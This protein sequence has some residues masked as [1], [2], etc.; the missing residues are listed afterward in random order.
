MHANRRRVV[1]HCATAR[2]AT[3]MRAWIDPGSRRFHEFLPSRS[4]VLNPLP[5]EVRQ[6]P[7]RSV[8][9]TCPPHGSTLEASFP[10]PTPLATAMQ[11]QALLAG[12]DP[13]ILS[14]RATGP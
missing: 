3:L 12:T 11:P 14:L 5:A 6:V 9:S 10:V 4:V 13:S 7:A 1:L 2:Q 8:P